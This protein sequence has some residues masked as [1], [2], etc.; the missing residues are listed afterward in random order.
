MQLAR[1]KW[2]CRHAFSGAAI[3]IWYD[4]RHGVICFGGPYRWLALCKSIAVVL[5]EMTDAIDVAA[6]HRRARFHL[7]L[8]CSAEQLDYVIERMES[9][10]WEIAGVRSFRR[11]MY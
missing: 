1:Q 8:K 9:V 5:S 2:I 6:S 4:L 3:G 10:G 11:L 7:R